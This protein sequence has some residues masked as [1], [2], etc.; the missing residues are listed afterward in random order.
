MK[1]KNMLK[2][3]IFKDIYFKLVMSIAF[4]A[5]ILMLIRAST[6]NMIIVVVIYVIFLLISFKTMRRIKNGKE[7]RGI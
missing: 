3:I 2:N 1:N 6:A 5:T 4:I 7:K